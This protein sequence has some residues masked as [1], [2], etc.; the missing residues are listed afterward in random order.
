MILQHP[1]KLIVL[2]GPP[3]CGKD[4]LAKNYERATLKLVRHVKFAR[5]LKVMTHR[6]YGVPNPEDYEQFDET[7]D[8]PN[9]EYFYGLTPRQAYIGVSETYIKPTHGLS[10]FGI[11][12]VELMKT[13]QEQAIVQCFV[14]SDGGLEEELLPVVEHCGAKNILVVKITREGYTFKGKGDSRHYYS[15]EFLSKL[16][17]ESKQLV[18]DDIKSF[19]DSGFLILRDFVCPIPPTPFPTTSKEPSLA[20]MPTS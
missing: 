4:T 1:P 9:F 11:K 6:L 5:Q 12:L 19:T 2:N 20:A 7:K 14:S 13:F 10:F 3:R 16:G 8:E 15:E 17:V 18:N